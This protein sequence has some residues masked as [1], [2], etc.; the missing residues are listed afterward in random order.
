LVAGSG[1]GEEPSGEEVPPP[2]SD[3]FRRRQG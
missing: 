3:P 1:T 2:D